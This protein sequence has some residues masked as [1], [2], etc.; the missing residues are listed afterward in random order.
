[1][2]LCCDEIMERI[3]SAYFPEENSPTVYS[4]DDDEF[5]PDFYEATSVDQIP[6]LMDLI[7]EDIA[8]AQ[9]RTEWEK[10]LA[11]IEGGSPH[12][13][14]HLSEVRLSLKPEAQ[15]RELPIVLVT[16]K[17]GSIEVKF[18]GS[19]DEAEAVI[20]SAPPYIVIDNIFW[21]EGDRMRGQMYLDEARTTTMPSPKAIMGRDLTPV[22]SL[23]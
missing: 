19:R 15:A 13:Y 16:D 23:R 18:P 8:R 1:M 2:I 17:T 10:Y 22:P 7:R 11:E 3:S 20:K 4:P 14:I 21:G 12:A 5:A 6:Q 9:P